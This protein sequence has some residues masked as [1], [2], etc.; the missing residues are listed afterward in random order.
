MDPKNT[1]ENAS[2]SSSAV[3]DLAMLAE[4]VEHLVKHCAQLAVENRELHEQTLTLQAER[5]ALRDKY[6]HSRA[7]IDAMIV[8]LKGLEQSS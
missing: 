8:R 1:N 2:P 6:E 3:A 7:R 4:R 5:D